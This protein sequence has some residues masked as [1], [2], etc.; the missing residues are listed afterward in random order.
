MQIIQIEERLYDMHG[1]M[2][3][4][5]QLS[6]KNTICIACN[7][8]HCPASKKRALNV[9]LML[10]HCLRFWPSIRIVLSG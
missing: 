10:V 1:M 7:D 3:V 8:G 9:V 6:E 5:I 2:R 4:Q